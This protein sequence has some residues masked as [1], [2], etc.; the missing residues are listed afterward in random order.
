[1][2]KIIIVVLIIL[3]FLGWFIFL[4]DR[5]SAFMKCYDS[6]GWVQLGNTS[7]PTC[8]GHIATEKDVDT[9]YGN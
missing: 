2:K 6:T 9:I 7:Q 8:G 1:M 5:R 4:R 3:L